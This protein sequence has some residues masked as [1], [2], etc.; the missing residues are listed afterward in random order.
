MEIEKQQCD[1]LCVGGGIAGLMAAIRAAELGAKVIVAEKSNTE[2]SGAGGA[3]NDHFQCYIPEA[4][5]DFQD[6][7]NEL[8]YGQSAGALRSMSQEYVRYWFENTFDV[9]QDWDR[10]GI[11]M[12]YEG[13]YE[14]AG[15]A[16]P[17]KMIN[18]LKYSGNNQKPMLTKQ[19]LT[20]GAKIVNRVMVFELLKSKAGDVIG[21]LGLDAREDKLIIF[22]AKSVVLGT[23]GCQRMY[24]GV[25]AGAENNR[26]WPVTLSGDGRAMAYRAG[27][28]LKN[29]ELVRRH[30]GPK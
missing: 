9:L 2:R 19:A 22:E 30:A 23:G 17:G 11:P 18:H 26:G 25:T 7:W 5:G 24:P 12:K 8:F 15:H 14:F 6:F 21:A 16:F 13:K 20:A 4:H 10:W 1:V 28:D 3:G 29:P 27:A